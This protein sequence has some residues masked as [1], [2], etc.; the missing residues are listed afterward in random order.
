MIDQTSSQKLT[1]AEDIL[2]G[3]SLSWDER[4]SSLL[5]A[6]ATQKETMAGQTISHYKILEKLGEGEP[7]RRNFHSKNG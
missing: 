4:T 7:V 1:I 2:S 6:G 5:L 3:K